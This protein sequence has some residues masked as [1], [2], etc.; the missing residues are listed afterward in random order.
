M[1]KNSK[2]KWIIVAV[3]AAALIGLI[4]YLNNQPASKFA[5]ENNEDN[6]VTVTAENAAKDASGMGY[7]TLQEGQKIKIRSNMTEGSS[8]LVEILPAEINAATKTLAEETITA[9]DI[10]TYELPAGDYTVRI[11]AQKGA[12]G[13]LD[14]YAE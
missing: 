5:V 11:T 9:V 3:L 6:T 2:T 12:K 8:M 4:L 7:I 1:M 13:T 10:L 14:I